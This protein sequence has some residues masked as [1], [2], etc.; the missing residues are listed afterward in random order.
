MIKTPRIAMRTFTVRQIVYKKDSKYL[1]VSLDL[2]LLAEGKTMGEA[3]DSLH[4]ASIGYLTMCLQDNESDEI[5]YRK[6]PKKYF[7]LYEL[8]KELDA[9]KSQ[10][11]ENFIGKAIYKSSEFI[12]A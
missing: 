3:M 2:D 7:D 8:F 9:K 6:A 5:I 12:N 1:A 4:E 11:K 10:V